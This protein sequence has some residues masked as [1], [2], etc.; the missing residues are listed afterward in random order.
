MFEIRARQK[1]IDTEIARDVSGIYF[2]SR[3]EQRDH[4]R[5]FNAPS[6]EIFELVVNLTLQSLIIKE[7]MEQTNNLKDESIRIPV[8]QCD[9]CRESLNIKKS[10][11]NHNKRIHKTYKETH[12]F[13]KES[14]VHEVDNLNPHKRLI[15]LEN[16]KL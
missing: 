13:Q 3:K 4:Y 11:K 15:L 1:N 9:Q 8:F 12:Q 5:R 14:N 16:W 2:V 7:N 6:S 10:I